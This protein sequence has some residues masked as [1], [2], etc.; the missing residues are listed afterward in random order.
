[1]YAA[2]NLLGLT[3]VTTDPFKNYHAATA[4]ITRWS[5]SLIICAAL[6]YFGMD[7]V[8]DVPSVNRL[9]MATIDPKEYVHKVCGELLDKFAMTSGPTPTAKGYKCPFCDK[10][11]MTMK[12]LRKHVSDKHEQKQP[13]GIQTTDRN[14]EPN[15]SES[16]PTA[17]P[18]G[19][20]TPGK[21]KEDGVYNYSCAALSY[22]L[23]LR[24][25][26]DAVRRGDGERVLRL[27]KF[28]MLYF[29]ACG[30]HKYAYHSLRLLVQVHHLLP[31][32]VAHQLMWNRFV[33]LSGKPDSN[34]PMDLFLEYMN[35]VFKL[36]CVGFHGNLTEE[37]VIRVS[38]AA[39]KLDQLL[40]SSD[41]QGS[42]KSRSGEHKRRDVK[43][44]VLGLVEVQHEERIFSQD[45]AGRHHHAFPGFQRHPLLQL[46][47]IKLQSWMTKSMKEFAKVKAFKTST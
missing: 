11:V 27:Y 12:S 15:R 23:L 19:T 31:P 36:D 3:N 7:S 32:R 18:G 20:S 4:L 24:N 14:S 37:S 6:T 29:K 42:V 8:S 33:N 34:F 1:M 47:Y 38:R 16:Q 5:D 2:R 28:L 26:Q 44:D 10:T 35:K 25:F 45:P 9:D 17:T 41:M 21:E 46:D 30:K 39:Q 22:F 40:H 43:Q 13:A